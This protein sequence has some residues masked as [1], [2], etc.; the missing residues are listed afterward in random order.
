MGKER[1]AVPDRICTVS[2]DRG[3]KKGART[4]TGGKR[5]T[6]RDGA[7]A[8]SAGSVSA[9][10]VAARP[11]APC[12]ESSEIQKSAATMILEGEVASRAD[13]AR[14]GRARDEP[15]RRETMVVYLRCRMQGGVVQ[16]DRGRH[17]RAR[18]TVRRSRPDHARR[19]R[20]RQACDW[21]LGST[22]RASGPTSLEFTPSGHDRRSPAGP[23]LAH[24]G[25]PWTLKSRT[26]PAPR[27]GI[28]GHR[29]R[30]PAPTR[31]SSET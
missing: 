22:R 31:T 10:A 12:K 4:S 20:P 18:P 1:N 21:L 29:I 5:R 30:M 26:H 7:R 14:A 2:L 19:E 16:S 27:E 9:G 23:N 25:A 24:P 11:G 6:T 17:R 15:G 13:H 8:E 3:S 28:K